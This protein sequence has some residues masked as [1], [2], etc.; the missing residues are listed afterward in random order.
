MAST[1]FR[2]PSETRAEAISIRSTRNSSNNSLANVSFS[3]VE[4]ETPEVCSPSRRVV[5]IISTVRMAVGII[6]GGCFE[7]NLVSNLLD[8]EDSRY[9]H[10][11][12]VSF[13]FCMD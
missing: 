2:S 1:A 11:H 9:R 4:K 8:S 7:Q 10:T 6:K 13:P 3:E 12:F 5:S